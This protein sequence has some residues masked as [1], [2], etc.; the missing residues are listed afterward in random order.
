MLRG[1]KSGF[2]LL[3]LLVVISVI[4][5]LAA[6]VAPSV[7]R[8]VSDAKVAAAKAQLEIFELALDAYHLDNDYYPT[9][10]Q[11]L[12]ALVHKPV[13]VPLPSNWRG[14]YVRR[15]IP[16]DPWGRPYVYRN[17]GVAGQDYL[18]STFGRD[19]VE[20]GAGD[21]AD[22]TRRAATIPK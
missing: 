22:L 21:D 16:I 8:N 19:G 12:D 4:A 5:I 7:F 14:P 9:T 17:E 10:T 3:E 11:G 6:I 18:L 13:G 20:G 2:S 1:R 15:E